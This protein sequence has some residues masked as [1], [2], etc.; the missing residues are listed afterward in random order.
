MQ[1]AIVGTR[2]KVQPYEHVAVEM[3]GDLRVDEIEGMV[4]LD[5]HRWHTSDNN[6]VSRCSMLPFSD[7]GRD[8][9]TLGLEDKFVFSVLVPSC[10]WYHQII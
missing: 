4:E 3:Y 7:E 1:R 9:V 8:T 6:R 2:L 10:L 5:G